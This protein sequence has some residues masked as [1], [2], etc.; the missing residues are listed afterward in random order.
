MS[1]VRSAT[2]ATHRAPSPYPSKPEG[3]WSASPVGRGNP[4]Q[5]ALPPPQK[6]LPHTP[7]SSHLIPATGRR[8]PVT[9]PGCTSLPQRCCTTGRNCR[10]TARPNPPPLPGGLIVL[11]VV[12][13]TAGLALP[14]S[15][16]IWSK[17]AMDRRVMNT[18][19]PTPVWSAVLP[20]MS[21]RPLPSSQRPMSDQTRATASERRRPQSCSTRAMSTMPRRSCSLGD[22]A[23]ASMAS[24]ASSSSAGGPDVETAVRT[25]GLLVSR[26][27]RGTER[28][29]SARR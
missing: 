5:S 12:P 28:T 21:R 9:R 13:K 19:S 29:P 27:N 14:W 10:R 25:T 3:C 2:S 7:H 22:R 17:A 16:W 26:R 11:A 15:C 24:I 6:L 8:G 4:G 1:S 23:V 18:T 20:S